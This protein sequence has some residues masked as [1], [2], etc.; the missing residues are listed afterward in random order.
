MKTLNEQLSDV[1]KVVTASPINALSGAVYK[2]DGRPPKSEEEDCVIRII[3]GTT[4]KH[5]QTHMLSVAIFYKA[6]IAGE[7]IT[8]DSSRGQVLHGMLIDLC[9]EINKL[10]NYVFFLNTREVYSEKVQTAA[11]YYAIL[12]INFTNI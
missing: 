2:N 6:H 8:E 9:E 1:Y 7:V 5:S 3:H 10:Q 12:R 11:Q 4:G